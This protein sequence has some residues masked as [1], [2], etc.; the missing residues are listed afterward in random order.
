MLKKGDALIGIV[1]VSLVLVSFGGLKAYK[2]FFGSSGHIAVII[3]DGR[4]LRSMNLDS[5][6]VAETIKVD[7]KYKHLI[8]VEPGR[9]RFSEA[10]CP[11]RICVRT[12]WLEEAGDTAVCIPD[13]I[14]I[15]VRGRADSIDAISY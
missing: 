7:G 5:D 8:I 1:L 15:K 4:V 6:L 3:Q 11:G 13:K 2:H 12:G 10:D 9:I 14:I